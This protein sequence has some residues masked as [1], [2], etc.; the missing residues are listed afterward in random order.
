M[1]YK[2]LNS[3]KFED[4]GEELDVLCSEIQSGIE[5]IQRLDGGKTFEKFTIMC[6]I[7]DCMVLW[8]NSHRGT[9]ITTGLNGT[10]PPPLPPH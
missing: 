10:N 1:A 5:K 7:Y 2:G 9:A 6:S 8:F 3:E 4:L